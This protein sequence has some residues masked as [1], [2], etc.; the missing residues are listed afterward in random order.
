MAGS[1]NSIYI[2]NP[3]TVNANT[4]LM[5]FGKSP[6]AP[7]DDAAMTFGNF[8]LQFILAG[9]QLNINQFNSGT[10]ASSSTFWRGDGTWATPV[11]S[12]PWIAG[13]GTNSAKGGAGTTAGGGNAVA[14]GQGNSA[15]GDNSASFGIGCASNGFVS[16]SWG[17]QSTSHNNGSFVI[18]D[19][20][21]SPATDSSNNQFV[22]TFTGGYS[23]YNSSSNLALRIDTSSNIINKKGTADQSY[24]LQVPSTGFSITI[25][26]DVKTLELNPAGTLA[27]GTITMPASPIDGQ[28][29][30]VSSTQTITALTVSPNSGQTISNAPTT[31]TAGTGFA[32][33]Y[34]LSG[35]KWIPLYQASLSGGGVSEADVQASAFN[36]GT[37]VG[38][39]ANA[40]ELDLS[41]AIAAYTDGLQ[42]FM[43][44][45]RANTVQNPTLSV[46][47]LAAKPIISNGGFPIQKSDIINNNTP[48]VVSFTYYLGIDSFILNNPATFEMSFLSLNYYGSSF[49]SGTA[50]AY[51]GTGIGLNTAPFLQAGVSCILYPAHDNTSAST[52]S[53]LNTAA[54]PIISSRTLLALTGGEIKTNVPCFFIFDG[55][56]WVLQN[57]VGPPISVVTHGKSSTSA[58]NYSIAG[59][60]TCVANGAYSFAMGNFAKTTHSGSHIWADQSS[61]TV[62]E[63]TVANMWRARCA[64]GF[65][66]SIS[67]SVDAMKIDANANIINTQGTADQAYSKRTVSSGDSFT[68]LPGVKTIILDSSGTVATLTITM[69]T[70]PI[71]GQEIR[72]SSSQIIT[73]LTLSPGSGQTISNAPTTMTAGSGFAYIYRAQGFSVWYRLY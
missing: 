65:D 24:S 33:T 14:Y 20:N 54:N 57:P 48:Q 50:N 12:N 22:S 43:I 56:N 69:P 55:T 38:M 64:G 41:P 3:I 7:A 26:G 25:S 5:H 53:Y 73:S 32:Y 11:S 29:I 45:T 52:F 15:A 31:L 40:Y 72:V 66:F 68:I 21:G 63:D 47:G 70:S 28:E 58:G 71:D 34:N 4:D 10:S 42:V 51:V 61:N 49:D 6:Y 8:K 62:F 18:S 37:D 59:G 2:A 39:T 60:F 16:F 23:F 46:N 19:S 44:T 67:D 9:A 35:T 17:S 1:I 27:T 30:R 13:S 36:I